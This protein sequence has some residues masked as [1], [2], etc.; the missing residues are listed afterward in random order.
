MTRSQANVIRAFVLWT[1]FV[2]LTRISNILRDDH[3]AS[4][5]VVHTG[6][7]LV[8]IVLAA[9]AWIVIARVRRATVARTDARREPTPDLSAR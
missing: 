3:D 7:A 9:G 6:L 5:K 1:A 8:S 2:W 4:F